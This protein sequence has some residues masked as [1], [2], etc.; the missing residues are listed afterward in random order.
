MRTHDNQ[1][2]SIEMILDRQTYTHDEGPLLATTAL[3]YLS[4]YR[5][6]LLDHQH[7]NCACTIVRERERERER[8]R[9]GWKW[10]GGEVERGGGSTYVYMHAG[11]PGHTIHTSNPSQTFFTTNCFSQ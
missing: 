8:E 10:G 4:E 2:L 1:S 3:R 11:R 6:S 7:L 5:D 9:V